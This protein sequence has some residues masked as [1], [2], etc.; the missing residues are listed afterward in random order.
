MYTVPVPVSVYCT[1]INM[2]IS[3]IIINLIFVCV[4]FSRQSYSCNEKIMIK[5]AE[6]NKPAYF[7]TIMLTC[8]ST[9]YCGQYGTNL[10]TEEKVNDYLA[11]LISKADNKHVDNKFV[12]FTAQRN[13]LTIKPPRSLDYVITN[14]GI[15]QIIMNCFMEDNEISTTFYTKFVGNGIVDGFFSRNPVNNTYSYYAVSNFGY[16]NDVGTIKQEPNEF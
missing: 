7:Q 16:P 5:E 15:A 12:P 10:F 8:P 9:R 2:L 6:G 14:D 1:S 3:L 11:G 4:P 13:P